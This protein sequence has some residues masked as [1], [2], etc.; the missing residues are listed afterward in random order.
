MQGKILTFYL[1]GE[2]FGIDI[3]LVKEIKRKI[4]YTVVPGARFYSR[5]V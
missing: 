3:R 2:L 4:K 1:Q 5:P